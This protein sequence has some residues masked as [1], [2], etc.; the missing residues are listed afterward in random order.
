[1]SPRA[2][3]DEN[4]APSERLLL[5][6]WQHQR[7]RRDRL[8]T[9]DGKIVRVLHPG[10]ISLEGGPDFRDAMIQIGDATARAG[11]VEIDLRSDGWHAHGHDRNPNFNNVILHV[12]WDAAGVYAGAG[13]RLNAPDRRPPGLQP[14][15]PTLSIKGQLDAPLAELG[16]ALEN[17]PLGSLPENLRGKC[18]APLRGLAE[19][20]L[21]ELLRAAAK[22]RLANKAGTMLARA[23]NSSWEQ[24]L[25]EHLF[26]A[27]GYEHNVWPLQNLAETK[28]RWGRGTHSAFA[29][30]ARLLGVSRLL[31]DDLT[32]A[33]KS[34]DTF[35]RRA[36]DAWWRGR[37]GFADC[38]LPRSACVPPTTRS[39]GSPWRRTGWR[40][41]I[42]LPKS[43]PGA[44]R[45][46]RTI[47]YCPLSMRFFR[48]N[49]MNSGRG[50]G[51]SNP[52]GCPDR[53]P[54]S[55]RRA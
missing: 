11:D 9:A 52:R 23:R 33:Q 53:S 47:N 38:L 41:K 54:C 15:P 13:H 39:A 4:E 16:L 48:L 19:A 55:A 30:Q 40:T 20:Q 12:V 43:R 26:R 44:R 1:M 46:C 45:K 17:E 22:V 7:L 14:L 34:S 27:L 37:D 25:W 21:T 8:E 18:S 50:I 2:L 51:R 5:A 42:S 31:P 3:R 28:P 6:L 29:L 32:W 49:A 35:L 10:F 36:W 24:A